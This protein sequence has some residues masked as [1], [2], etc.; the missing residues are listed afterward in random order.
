[1]FTPDGRP[2][3][4]PALRLVGAESPGEAPS[5]PAPA[6]L[7]PHAFRLH[8][9]QPLLEPVQREA[10]LHR[11]QLSRARL[12][13]LSAAAGC[14]KTT[15]MEQWVARDPRPSAWLQI[16][17]DDNDPLVFLTYLIETAGKV[18]ALDPRLSRWLRLPA[19][20]VRERILPALTA[21]LQQ[22]QPFLLVL[23]DLHLLTDDDVWAIAGL[24]LDALPRGAQLAVGSRKEPR[25]PLARLQAAGDLLQLGSR[26]LAFDTPETAE[27]LRLRH[28][29]ASEPEIAALQTATEGWAAGLQLVLLAGEGRPAG[30]WIAEVSGHSRDIARY[31]TSEVLERQPP[32]V[33]SFLLRTSILERLSGD[34]CAAVTGDPAAGA[35]LERLAQDNVFLSSLDG[36]GAAYRYHHLFAELLRDELGRRDPEEPGELHRRAA[37][38]YERRGMTGEAIAH[39]LAAGD[40]ERAAMLFCRAFMEYSAQGRF[41][42]LFRWLELF[43]DEQLLSSP[44]LTLMAGFP[45]FW[46]GAQSDSVRR[47]VDAALEVEIGD[48]PMPDGSTTMRAFQAALRASA[49]RKGITQARQDA[50]LAATAMAS[51]QPG[52][53]AGNASALG[54][55]QWLAGDEAE[56]RRTLLETVDVG[57]THNVFAFL[58][59]LS[60]LSLMAADDGRWDEAEAYAE[61][62]AQRLEAEELALVAPL[63]GV[64]AAE[65]RVLAHKRDPLALDRVEVVAQILDSGR[66]PAIL[67]LLYAAVLGE[68]ALETGDL[69]AARHWAASGRQ[70]LDSWPDAGALRPRLERL[71]KALERACLVEPL[72]PAERRLLELLPSHMSLK[73]I[74]GKLH[75]SRETVK[76]ETGGLYR[77]LEVHSRSEAVAKARACGLLPRR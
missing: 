73:E 14:G 20:P 62:A 44:V 23:D 52:M 47:W 68:I 3:T 16:A 28:I 31:F 51:S 10:I 66:L 71:E 34:L 5:S 65:A 37:A 12:V 19:P 41:A 4:A 76:T 17:P 54:L 64:P 53:R 33:R 7:L 50:Q 21:S 75:V 1:M 2:A 74:A 18:T 22:A 48:D 32:D 39:W 63:V 13:V 15:V 35:T 25:L 60:C 24:L 58:G 27:L 55:Y 9:P 6:G 45:A 70:T 57:S 26:D 29:A 49:G 30:D 38:W 11:L 69:P 77:K 36:N 40:D 59:A 43:T 61:R 8:P 46:G 42:T 72:T 67:A 56:A